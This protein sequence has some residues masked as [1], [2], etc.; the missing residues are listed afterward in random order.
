MH[1]LYLRIKTHLSVLTSQNSSN[2]S[3]LKKPPTSGQPPSV[4]T[5]PASATTTP[6]HRH[7][8][9]PDMELQRS[10]SLKSIRVRKIS[11]GSLKSLRRGTVCVT[12]S[13]HASSVFYDTDTEGDYIKHPVLYELSYK[14]GFTDNLPESGLPSRLEE[15]KEAIRREIRKELKIK[16]GAEKLREVAKDRRSLNDV[17]A[18]VKKSNNKIAELK[19]ELQELESQ[20]LLTQG[21]DRDI[22]SPTTPNASL[23]GNSSDGNTEGNGLISG[24][25]EQLSAND[26]LLLS[27]EKQLNIEMKVKNGAENM[28]QS[29]QSGHYGRDKK[30]LGEA[31]QMLTDSKAKIEFLRLRILKVKQNKEHAYKLSQQV[32]VD[33]ADNGSSAGGLLPQR[34][35]TSL[36]ERIEELRHRLRIE[37]AVVDGAKNVIRILRNSK[38]PD[39]KALQEA[40]AR[41]SESSRKLDLLCHSL[42]LRR[43]ELPA[44]SLAAQQ[45]KSELQTVQQASSP[46]PFNYTSLQPFHA[47]LLGGKPYQQVST[48][49]RC[50]SVTGKLEVR[51]MGCQGL[52]E[53]VP[54]R[55]RRDKDNNSSPG[56]LRSFVKGVTSRSS[57]KSYSVKDETSS[58][59]M[60]VIKL[61]NMTVAQTSWKPCSQQAW[62]QRFSIDLDRSRELEI[63][64]YWRDWRSL[65]AVKFL[66]LEE[67]IDDVRHGMALQLEPQG[68]LFAEI[69]FLNPMISQK[70]KLRRQ[71]MI[72]NKQQVK[73][74]P[75]A[76]QMNINVATWGRLLKRNAPSNTI[77]AGGKM[78][79]TRDSE[80]PISRTPSSGTIDQEP[81]PYSPG[82]LA[83]NMQYDPEAGSTEHIETPGECPDPS[84]SGLSG[85]RPLSMQ[86]IAAL[87]PE[88]VATSPQ[89]KNSTAA[90]NNNLHL[91]ITGKLLQ[92]NPIPKPPTS[93]GSKQTTPTDVVPPPVPATSP[94][95]MDQELQSALSEFD[96]LNQLDSQPNTLQ[97]PHHHHNNQQPQQQQQLQQQMRSQ[98]QTQQQQ[99]PP[100]QNNSLEPQSPGSGL[101]HRPVLTMPPVV[102]M[103]GDGGPSS[104]SHDLS[105]P[106][107]EMPPSPAPIVE[108]PDD[109]DYGNYH[110]HYSIG[111]AD[112]FHVEAHINLVHITIE[113]TIPLSLT[114]T[115]SINKALS[116]SLANVSSEFVASAAPPPSSS[117]A[118][119]NKN[120]KL[121]HEQPKEQEQKQQNTKLY[122]NN[123]T[124]TPP[125]QFS[126]SIVTPTTTKNVNVPLSSTPIDTAKVAAVGTSSSASSSTKTYIT[127]V[128]HFI[129]DLEDEKD[130]Q[131][132]KV[133]PQFS[134]VTI[135]NNN[136]IQL[137][138]QHSTEPSPIIQEPQTPI[139]YGGHLSASEAA[140]PHFPQPAQR[141]Q[142]YQQPSQQQPP[143]PSAAAVQQQQQPIYQNQFELQ[144]AAA[145]A[146]SNSRRNVAR[147]LQYRDSA[148][149]SRRQSQ[150]ITAPPGILSMDNFRML[151][152]LGRGHFGKVILCQLRTNNQYYAIKALKKGDIIAR[153]EVESL[154]SEKRI[155][156]VANAMRHPFLVNLYA[157]FQTE[158]HVCFVMEYAAGG[159]L[160]M[161]IHT[162]VFSEPRAVFYAACVVLGLQY[163]HE[164]KIIYRDLKLDNLLL[165]TEGYV[166]IADFGLCKEGMGFGDRTGT[167]CGTP[168]FLA[169][170]VLTETSYTR[171]VD[172]WGLGV[173]IFEMLVGESPFPGDD[174]EEVFDSIVND[175]VR[176]PRFLSLEAIAIMRR[177][178]RKNPERRL[179]SSERD[180]ED[181]KRQA[182]FRS[183]VWDDLLLRRVRP[184]FVPTITHLE[185]VSN[186][187]EEFTSERPQLTPPKEPR[188]LTDEEQMFFQDF[189]YTAEWS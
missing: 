18:I 64:V 45:L 132:I 147:G 76:K 16:E 125:P 37:A 11:K 44:D 98:S 122:F 79:A 93:A 29:L 134:N 140:A 71:Q 127:T 176:Y 161:H 48:L 156:E 117:S 26:K 121:Q 148:Y 92:P 86:G 51:L 82:I 175:E 88:V 62:D 109:E 4:V 12:V 169:P 167:F 7:N 123:G 94:P 35:E 9:A 138:Q 85:K 133:I 115:T 99:Q 49:G 61:D 3:P 84:V 102:I 89:Q 73:N 186:F 25:H 80:S 39:K 17:A 131:E 66:R 8:S 177:L 136:N 74:I 87:P 118:C 63:G 68:L 163:L 143:Q 108:Y 67:F 59:I 33:A 182:F 65:C 28:I 187:D 173:L 171:A 119:N 70:P 101:Y 188:V 142:N 158:Q 19:S 183:I 139:V 96:F 129:T 81:E 144:N 181:V 60:A 116:S 57:S 112:G 166:K 180:A 172:W 24:G 155:F 83:Q 126:S 54:G 27:L 178:L 170:E 97:R 185:D 150:N 149:E 154:L 184:P 21:N 113:P 168:E 43:L 145:A 137:Q 130:T 153:D 6:R 23:G 106:I 50:A 31:Q 114:T 110:R 10:R 77:L 164:N 95:K 107:I 179:G 104:S 91:N 41:L 72:F 157:C 162:D 56:D 128:E 105:S 75:R 135:S 151:S 174:E 152:V 34:L 38:V 13:T 55:S 103:G 141:Q 100:L 47:G 32:A 159:D 189:T 5:T 1:N 111:A 42:D 20:I 14:Y 146:Q 58:E 69:K 22:L 90:A 53:D 40:H 2:T 52:L 30:L 165:D 160:M 78:Q 46:V 36:E 124:T 15:I 120:N